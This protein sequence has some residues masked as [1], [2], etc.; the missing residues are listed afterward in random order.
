VAPLPHVALPFVPSEALETVSGR[1]LAPHGSPF[2]EVDQD[3]SRVLRLGLVGVG[4]GLERVRHGD[5]VG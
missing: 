4:L 5:L 3:D 1:S 2:R